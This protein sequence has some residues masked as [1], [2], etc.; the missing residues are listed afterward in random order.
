[1]KNLYVKNILNQTNGEILCGTT[2][3]IIGKVSIDT[4]TIKKDETYVALKG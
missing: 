2:D 4:R 1:M 3:K